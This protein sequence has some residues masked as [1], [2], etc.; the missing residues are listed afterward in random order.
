MTKILSILTIFILALPFLSLKA[1]ELDV[2]GDWELT[3]ITQRGERTQDIHF[4]QNGE[5]LTVTMAGFQGHEVK[6][7]G[8]LKEN[9]IEWKITRSTPRGEMTITYA[10]EVEGD[11]MS[12]QAQM[13]SF[14]TFD[15]K[16]VRKE[17]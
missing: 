14:R 1:E 11:K 8:T 15:W 13:G 9:K 6:G 16:A 3:M 10:G 4:E 17:S 2:S 7:E 12:G 5:N